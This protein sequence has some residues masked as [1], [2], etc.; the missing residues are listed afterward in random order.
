MHNNRWNK[1]NSRHWFHCEMCQGLKCFKRP[2]DAGTTV[3]SCFLTRQSDIFEDVFFPPS[4]ST[5]EQLERSEQPWPLLF[6]GFM[7]IQWDSWSWQC[8]VETKSTSHRCESTCAGRNPAHIKSWALGARLFVEAN[9]N[10]SH[11]GGIFLYYTG[12]IST[13]KSMSVND[14]DNMF[15][16]K[17]LS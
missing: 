2:E 15:F 3:R 6:L 11:L 8:R 7:M 1:T 17:S 10:V 13:S 16:G 9:L 14:Y 5:R 12:S 4:R